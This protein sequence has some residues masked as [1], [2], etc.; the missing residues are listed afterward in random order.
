[1]FQYQEGVGSH[2]MYRQICYVECYKDTPMLSLL[3]TQR[4]WAIHICIESWLSVTFNRSFSSGPLAICKQLEPGR[5]RNVRKCVWLGMSCF[6]ESLP[7]VGKPR[8][9]EAGTSPSSMATHQTPV[10]AA[11]PR[12]PSWDQKGL[13]TLS[14]FL[15][16]HFLISSLAQPLS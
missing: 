8:K 15:L 16:P 4:L 13:I 5:E 12:F 9:A 7:R 11:W 3:Q 10:L 2:F 1:M 6:P 14:S